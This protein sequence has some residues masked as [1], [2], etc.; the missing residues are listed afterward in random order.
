MMGKFEPESP[1]FDGNFTMVS[2]KFSRLNQPNEFTGNHGFIDN[3]NL[4][5]KFS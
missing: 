2:C 5:N 3:G 4:W 1:I